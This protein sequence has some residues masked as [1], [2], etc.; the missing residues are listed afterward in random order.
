MDTGS[1]SAHTSPLPCGYCSLELDPALTA[2]PECGTT[3]QTGQSLSDDLRRQ[4]RH[5]ALAMGVAGIASLVMLTV[6][7]DW[8][9]STAGANGRVG[10][11]ALFFGTLAFGVVLLLAWHW[12]SPRGAATFGAIWAM[13][14]LAPLF[15]AAALSLCAIG[16]VFGLIGRWF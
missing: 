1:S 14:Y 2:C 3:T 9:P 13:L 11:I 8:M 12:R 7:A 15:W 16:S 4:R 5:V 6:G 10:G